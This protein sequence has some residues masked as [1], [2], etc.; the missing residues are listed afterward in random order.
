[1]EGI[2]GHIK[3][4][5]CVGRRQSA[6]GSKKCGD[7]RVC[8]VLQDLIRFLSTVGVRLLVFSNPRLI[9]SQAKMIASETIL[10]LSQGIK[11]Q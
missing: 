2:P 7:Q 5:E 9:L 3:E 8:R 6:C 11:K 1:M 10:Y 4:D